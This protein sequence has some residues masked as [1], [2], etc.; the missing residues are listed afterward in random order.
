MYVRGIIDNWKN[1]Q[2]LDLTIKGPS[3]KLFKHNLL[4]FHQL[5]LNDWMMKTLMVITDNLQ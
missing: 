2:I 3:E 1:R 4:L 5:N